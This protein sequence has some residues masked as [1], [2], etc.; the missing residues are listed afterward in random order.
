[1]FGAVG[2]EIDA[3][4]DA[5]QLALTAAHDGRASPRRDYACGVD[6]ALRWAGH[7]TTT[8]PCRRSP[9]TAPRALP[10]RRPD[11]AEAYDL[12]SVALRALT[13]LGR[14]G[15]RRTV[16]STLSRARI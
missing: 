8:A 11:V 10:S 3:R 9:V 15:L 13:P 2:I 7:A 14:S 16:C 4:F 5:G 6:H 1:M 12:D